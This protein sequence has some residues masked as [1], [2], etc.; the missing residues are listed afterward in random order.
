MLKRK[1]PDTVA[2]I[3]LGSNSFHMI[4]AQIKDGHVHVLD[5]L[6]E[7][8][9]MADGLDKHNIITEDARA[10]ALDCL[11]RFGQRLRG[12]P[13]GSVRVVG[14]N[15]L[16]RARNASAFI[17]EAQEV[18][19][20]PI[21]IISGREEAR[22]I[23]LGVSHTWA[24]V[25]VRRLVVDIGGGS[26][27]LIIGEHFEPTH[28]ESLHMGCVSMTRSYFADGIITENAWQDAYT[29]ARLEL[30]P[31]AKLYRDV[32]WGAAVGASGTILTVARIVN[33]MGWSDAGI[34][35]ESL[36]KL[37]KAMLRAGAVKK[38]ELQGLS[39]DRAE[40]MAGGVVVLEAVFER[41]RIERMSISDG[42]VREGL[43]YDLVGRIRHEDVRRRTIDALMQRYHVDAAHATRVEA[44]ALRLFDMVANDWGLDED[45][46]DLL[47]WAT[48]LHEVGL[49]IA[50]SQYHKHGAYL[51]RNADL[52][53]FSRQEQR[54]LATLVRAHR[55]KFPI[56]EFEQLPDTIQREHVIRLA[57]V[58]RLA[59]LLNR[60]RQQEHVRINSIEVSD[61]GLKLDIDADVLESHPLTHADL[62]NERNYLKVSKIKLK[63]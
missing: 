56:E 5:K 31:I 58:L 57:V 49:A 27:E 25:D 7:T 15:T 10:R 46:A 45:H 39:K 50:H 20:H 19:G 23:Y 3:D 61:T 28:M 34:T 8:I 21:D 1:P 30:R 18:L 22:L 42:A 63:F 43:I 44:T 59:I 12:M 36:Q 55:R 38:L 14:T 47:S 51:L 41:L 24:D 52:P 6:K 40:I 60:G 11:S 35:A 16:R 2:A 17:Y 33:M 29:A 9:R 4:V 53:G 13:R 26:T 48:R 62:E 54:M 32:G 37:R